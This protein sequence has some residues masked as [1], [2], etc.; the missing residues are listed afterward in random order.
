MDFMENKKKTGISL[1]G[2]SDYDWRGCLIDKSYSGY[3]FILED[4]CI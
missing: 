2:Y 4:G 3:A 1:R